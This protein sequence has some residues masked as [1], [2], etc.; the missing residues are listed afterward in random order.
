MPPG[1]AT[2]LV[3]PSSATVW[4][5]LEM[6]APHPLEMAQSKA[7]PYKAAGRPA[8]QRGGAVASNVIREL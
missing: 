8:G 4:T 2:A 7:P 5:W 3:L 1:L 6:S